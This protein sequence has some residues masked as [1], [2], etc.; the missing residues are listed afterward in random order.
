MMLWGINEAEGSAFG[1]IGSGAASPGT[2]GAGA[3]AGAA[4]A[5]GVP[6]APQAPQA[7]QVVSQATPHSHPLQQRW[8]LNRRSTMQAR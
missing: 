3:A 5:A 1:A 6:Q 8:Q 7:P 4:G 2:F